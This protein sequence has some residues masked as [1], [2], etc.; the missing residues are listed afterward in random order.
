MIENSYIRKYH[1]PISFGSQLVTHTLNHTNFRLAVS[2]VPYTASG[3]VLFWYPINL[4]WPSM[5]WTKLTPFVV[6]CPL[7]FLFLLVRHLAA[8]PSGSR[9]NITSCTISLGTL[10]LYSCFNLFCIT[11]Y[12]RRHPGPSSSFFTASFT[13]STEIHVSEKCISN[14][15]SLLSRERR[16]HAYYGRSR[17]RK[18]NISSHRKPR[19]TYVSMSSLS[20]ASDRQVISNIGSHFVPFLDYFPVSALL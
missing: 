8:R 1:Q 4:S 20:F 3:H 2:T 17:T 12:P 19:L 15:R 9:S 11:L 13:S 14:S 16:L 10:S 18:F 6:N 5:E 7:T